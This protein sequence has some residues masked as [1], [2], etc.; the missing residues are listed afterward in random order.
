V[1]CSSV[2][3]NR[4]SLVPHQSGPPLPSYGLGPVTVGFLTL[5]LTSVLKVGR[6]PGCRLIDII[7]Y[8]QCSC[9]GYI[10]RL[11]TPHFL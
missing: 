11:N 3:S 4:P 7:A 10:G 6:S 5:A 9:L 8:Y 1:D 2:T